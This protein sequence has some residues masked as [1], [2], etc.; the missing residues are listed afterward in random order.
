M[1]L[2][3]FGPPGAGKGTQAKRLAERL[4]LIHLSTG[5]MLRAAVAAGTALGRK[6]K[7]TMD[8]GGLVSDDL[9]IAL[10]SA[11]IDA[12]DC[13]KGFILDGFPRTVAQAE[14]LDAMLVEKGLSVD[15]VIAMEVDDEALIERLTGRFSCAECGAGY[16]VT[17]QRPAVDGVCDRCGGRRFDRRAD[18][19]E[20]TV[21]SR[22]L[23]YRRKT[24]PLLPYYRAK[25]TLQTVDGMAPIEDVARQIETV[26]A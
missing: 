8:A 16:H 1:N 20:E 15:S 5:E 24:T 26:L 17:L 21:R 3:L 18:D 9:M 6:A 4:S 25:G 12:P 2:I 22:L 23:A 19:N 14:A 10:I 7:A 11:R 13:A